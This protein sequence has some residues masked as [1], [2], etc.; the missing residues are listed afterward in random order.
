MSRLT[1]NTSRLW[2]QVIPG[3]NHIQP[4]P[5][6]KVPMMII[7]T[8]R[9]RKPRQKERIATRRWRKV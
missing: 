3:Q 4:G 9:P 7:A 8:H 1:S 2:S 5:R 6:M